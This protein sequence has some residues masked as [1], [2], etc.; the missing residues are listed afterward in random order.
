MNSLLRVFLYFIVGLSLMG[1]AYLYLDKI[2]FAPASNF[3]VVSETNQKAQNGTDDF[4]FVGDADGKKIYSHDKSYM[5]LVKEKSVKIYVA[6]K[7]KDVI[8]INLDGKEVSFFEW[9]D[10]RNLAV[11]GLYG[12][13]TPTMVEF[14]QLNPEKPDHMSYTEIKDLPADSKIT[15]VVYSTAT[16]VIYMKIQVGENAYRVYRTDANYDTRRIYVRATNVGRI[17]VFYDEDKFFYDNQRTGEI[18]LYE[19]STG[20]WRIIS[21]P[22]KYYLIGLDDGKNIYIAKMNKDNEVVS[23]SKGRLGVGFKEVLTYETPRD[24]KSLTVAQVLKEIEE[25]DKK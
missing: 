15:N 6:G 19:D 12:G 22:G 8:D 7:P 18:F 20:G 21:P 1:G 4:N 25:K 16:N 3:K 17:A 11:L 24:F 5:A 10:D 13:K 14:K 23:V 2:Y 9:L